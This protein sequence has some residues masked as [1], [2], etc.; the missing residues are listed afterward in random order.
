MTTITKLPD[1]VAGGSKPRTAARPPGPAGGRR[2]GDLKIALLFI[3]PAMIGFVVFYVVPTIRG[4]YLSFT[5]YSILGDP[6][7]VGP[8][9]YTAIS[10]DALFWNATGR[11]R[12]VRR[13]EHRLSRPPSPWAWPC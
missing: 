11:H 8:D 7:W 9:N 5:E 10:T 6:D 13:P 12:P 4:V 3:L 1:P 2:L